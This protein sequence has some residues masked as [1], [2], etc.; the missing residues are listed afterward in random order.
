MMLGLLLSGM[1]GSTA[2]FVAHSPLALPVASCSS[3][4]RMVASEDIEVCSLPPSSDHTAISLPRKTKATSSL[5]TTLNFQ[6]MTPERKPV[7]CSLD[8]SGF[9]HSV[10]CAPS[11][12][13]GRWVCPAFSEVCDETGVTL[14]R[15]MMEMARY[16]PELGEVESIFTSVQTAAKTISNLVRR[17]SLT[18]ITGLE[19]G[20][21][22]INVQGEEQKKLDLITND[23]LKK[24]LKWTGKLGTLASEEEDAPV[25][26]D[27]RGNAVFSSDVLVEQEGRYVAVF[28]PLDGSSNVDAGIPTGTIFGIFMD[29]E[30][31]VIADE[32]PDQI[33]N[34]EEQRCLANTLQPGTNLVAAGYILYSSATSFVFTLGSGVQGFTLDESIGEFVMTHPNI[35]IPSRGAIYSFNESNRWDWDQPLQDYITDIQ[36]ARGDTKT[37]YSSRYIGS[38]VADVHRTLQYGGI[39]GYPADKKNP[40][41]KLRLL[42]EAAPMSFLMEQAGGLA[43]TGKNRI[44]DLNPQ[45]VHQRVP[46]ILGSP[47]DV[48]ELRR[49]YEASDDPEL[50]KRCDA[51]LKARAEMFETSIIN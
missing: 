19:G 25:L 21:G 44:M 8:L 33:L 20:G 42:Y 15:Y 13:T 17:S 9:T 7:T 49:Y 32:D 35:Q 4:L 18:G 50:I 12:Q 47:E 34:P 37:K 2:A 51:R 22:S 6:R 36:Q 45:Q 41:G 3:S 24:A 11:L 5:P 48:G 10:H 16:N 40:D 30:Q 31:C 1:L 43:L 27:N 26:V 28:D 39:F 29:D 23:V 14:S 38:M 46:C